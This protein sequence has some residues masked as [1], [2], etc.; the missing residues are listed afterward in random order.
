[1]TTEIKEFI[2]D[3]CGFLIFVGICVGGYWVYFL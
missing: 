1:M 2:Q 3:L